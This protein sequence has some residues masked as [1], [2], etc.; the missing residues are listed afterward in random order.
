MRPLLSKSEEINSTNVLTKVRD[1]RRFIRLIDYYRDMWRKRAHTVAPLTKLC[2][3]KVKFKWTEVENDAFIYMKKIVG[4][5]VLLSCP[6]VNKIFI[7]HTDTS[8]T[9]LGG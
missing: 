8:K 6:N 2:L 5:G 4:G 1:M 7:I 9:Q 3:S